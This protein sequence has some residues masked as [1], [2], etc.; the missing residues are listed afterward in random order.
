M[1]VCLGMGVGEGGCAAPCVGCAAS[2][3]ARVCMPPA[4][5]PVPAPR[6][7]APPPALS[8]PCLQHEAAC[9][10]ADA[11][12]AER[13]KG[14]PA[15]GPDADPWATEGLLVQVS[16]WCGRRRHS[17]ASL[18][19]PLHPCARCATLPPS[20]LVPLPSEL[21][22]HARTRPLSTSAPSLGLAAGAPQAAACPRQ[23]A[24]LPADRV[25][26]HKGVGGVAAVPHLAGV[27]PRDLRSLGRPK[28]VW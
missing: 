21:L 17:L 6:H 12:A 9:N 10:A 7:T 16:W 27:Q 14:R 18:T 24:L 8:P 2:V 5:A 3:G 22:M 4:A 11:V 15:R 19:P 26:A 13:Q 23:G 28:L 1:R 20:Q 25:L